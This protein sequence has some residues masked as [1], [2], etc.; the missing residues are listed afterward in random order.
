MRDS[1]PLRSLALAAGVAASI[2]LA[3][4]A[5]HVPHHRHVVPAEVTLENEHGD[6]KVVVVHREPAPRRHCW[7]HRRH[8]HCQR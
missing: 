3:G 5:R 1:T 2:G 8:W 4:C 6:A 7:R